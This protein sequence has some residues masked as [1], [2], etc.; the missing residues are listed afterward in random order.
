MNAV[1][2]KVNAEINANPDIKNTI[3]Y[4]LLG[5]SSEFPQLKFNIPNLEEI[6]KERIKAHNKDHFKHIVIETEKLVSAGAV[7]KS[8]N[9]Y[10]EPLYQFNSSYIPLLVD[11]FDCNV[12]N[13][14]AQSIIP[15]VDP[16][17]FVKKKG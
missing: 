15:L 6:C 12:I 2:Q 7:K 9:E 11:L 1:I 4:R 14:Q 17:I 5:T 3:H 13:E 10:G 8:K 16:F